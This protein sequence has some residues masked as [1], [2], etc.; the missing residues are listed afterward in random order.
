MSEA[1]EAAHGAAEHATAHSPGDYIMHHVADGHEFEIP[2]GE[3]IWASE[4]S[5]HHLFGDALKLHI[6]GTE[7]D[8]TPTKLTLY[9]FVAAILVVGLLIAATRKRGAVPKGKL[10]TIVEMLFLFVRDEIA[11]KNI[12]HH[13]E[14][15]VPYL[16]TCFF[17]I[18]GMNLVGLVPYFAPAT[19]SVYVTGV[20]ALATFAVTQIAGMRA[21]GVVGYWSHLVPSGVP[22]WLYPLLLPIEFIGLFTKPF[23]LMMRLFAN[24][25]AGH[26][27]IF[28]LLGLI[29]FLGAMA[30]PIAVPFAF[31]IFLL[32]LFVA[33]IQAYVFT[34]LSAVF[35]GL[36]SHAH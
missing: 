6:G 29:F 19:S 12:G 14:K 22:F 18:L 35:I 21:Q 8:L 5:T 32:E 16:A 7:V 31:G 25:V 9:M 10:Q 34:I 1:V 27:V 3:H 30:I 11:E 23:A 26:I 13:S 36:A 4:V 28:F 17:F 15:Y 24:M 33:F 20:L 2:G